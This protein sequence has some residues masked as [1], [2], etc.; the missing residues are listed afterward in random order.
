MN[1]R[2]GAAIFAVALAAV[3][4][5][6]VAA[7]HNAGRSGDWFWGF[8]Q[9]NLEASTRSGNNE[10]RINCL[11]GG[12]VYG[13]NGIEVLINGRPAAGRASFAFN[14]GAEM[15]FRLRQGYF[16]VDNQR[17]L[18]RFR[19]FVGNLRAADRVSVWTQRDGVAVFSLYGSSRALA[20]C[21]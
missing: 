10:L 12:A 8:G 11:T 13:T 18:R 15:R 20:Y 21:G 3:A 17:K 16:G 7:Q 9:G 4:T 19:R 14:N 5:V 1:I 6:A 2:F